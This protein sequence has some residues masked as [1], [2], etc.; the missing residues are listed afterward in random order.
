MNLKPSR[1]TLALAGGAVLLL[2]A[3]TV[4]VVA[5]TGGEGCPFT[6]PHATE[7]CATW[8]AH[9]AYCQDHP[10]EGHCAELLQQAEQARYCRDH[11]DDPRCAAPAAPDH[12]QFC[13]DHPDS[14]HCKA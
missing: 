10:T 7:H 13:R 8:D 4:A 14:P 11:A 1:K 3:G 9:G 2:A 6:G 5:A 12:A